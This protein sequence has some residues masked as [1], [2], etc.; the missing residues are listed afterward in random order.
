[1]IL[2]DA[3]DILEMKLF[4]QAETWLNSTAMTAAAKSMDN[5][6]HGCCKVMDASCDL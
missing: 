4:A 3:V 6:L 5:I 1:M 2:G